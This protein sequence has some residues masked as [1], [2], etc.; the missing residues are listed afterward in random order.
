[1]TPPPGSATN[2]VIIERIDLVLTRIS[3]LER[4]LDD[5]ERERSR[6]ASDYERRHAMLDAKADSTNQRLTAHE[7]ADKPRWLLVDKLTAEVDLLKQQ[8]TELRHANRILSWI[9]S[10]LGS[11]LIL[12]LVGQLLGLI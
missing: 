10:I 9:A 11:A 7:D 8:V 2:A 6:F 12:W 1:M 3:T 5:L 4:H